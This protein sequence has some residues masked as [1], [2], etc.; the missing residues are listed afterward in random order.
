MAIRREL[1]GNGA[2]SLGGCRRPGLHRRGNRLTFHPDGGLAFKTSHVTRRSG[3]GNWV[4]QRCPAWM[5]LVTPVF[6]KRPNLAASSLIQSED[7]VFLLRETSMAAEPS[8]L[9]SV[10]GAGVVHRA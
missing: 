1:A 10:E 7:G 4:H 3:T 8:P 2:L 9:A 5:V 6:R